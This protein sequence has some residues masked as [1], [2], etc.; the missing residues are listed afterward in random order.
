M[1]LAVDLGIPPFRSF[2]ETWPLSWR[3]STTVVV[4]RLHPDGTSAALRV[5][6]SP[7][8]TIGVGT[9]RRLR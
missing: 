5:D 9:W 4:F 3:I 7:A 1:R 8:R 2:D 6:G